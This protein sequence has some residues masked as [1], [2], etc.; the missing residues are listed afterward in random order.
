MNDVSSDQTLRTAFADLRAVEQARIRPPGTG[1]AHRTVRR[2]RHRLG[3]VAA[4]AGL[5]AIMAVSAGY[6]AITNGPAPDRATA[7]PASL[8]AQATTAP[9]TGAHQPDLDRITLNALGKLPA[10]TRTVALADGPGGARSLPMDMAAKPGR[11]QLK[12]ACGGDGT[13][14]ATISAGS[15]VVTATARCATTAD[16]VAAGVGESSVVDAEPG[17]AKVTVKGAPASPDRRVVLLALI[18]Q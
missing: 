13:V 14:T 15:D 12:L 3:A 9:G 17:T 4:T 11:F 8:V 16:G 6:L 10:G 5:T 7:D 18:P 1:A 2:R